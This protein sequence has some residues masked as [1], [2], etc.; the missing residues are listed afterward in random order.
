ML[1]YNFN[2]LD[3]DFITLWSQY[4]LYNDTAM[5]IKP[6]EELAEKG[7]INAIQ[8]WYLLKK[9]EEQ[10]ATI[11]A[12]VDGYYGDSFNESLAIAHRLYSQNKQ[13]INDLKEKA[14]ETSKRYAEAHK[15]CFYSE[16]IEAEYIEAIHQYLDTEYAKQYIKTLH[17]AEQTATS[18]SSATAWQ[19]LLEL[20][21]ADPIIYAH[22][23]DHY[24]IT[25]K[26]LNN[27]RKNLRNGLKQ[28]FAD[29]A[30]IKYALGKNLFFFEINKKDK[31]EG[32]EI[33]LE[34]SKRP[35]KHVAANASQAEDERI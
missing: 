22:S 32:R 25:G 18:L 20:Y 14:V 26:F 19:R 8:S 1:E 27:I 31:Q 29:E 10:N 21:F 35:L 24:K 30:R 9:P 33:L 28:R 5:I 6:L 17:L 34:L 3:D 11:D 13:Q 16:R 12:I 15:Q 23:D 4:L 7:Q 2:S